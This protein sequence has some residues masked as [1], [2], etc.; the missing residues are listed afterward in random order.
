M[1]HRQ[2]LVRN[3]SHVVYRGDVIGGFGQEG[4]QVPATGKVEI[5]LDGKRVYQDLGLTLT[6]RS[7][8][9]IAEPS[10]ASAGRFRK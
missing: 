9:S 10:Q 6:R 7:L 5:H 3:I 1:H 8:W 4:C 2:Y